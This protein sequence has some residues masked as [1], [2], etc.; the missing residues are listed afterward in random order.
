MARYLIFYKEPVMVVVDEFFTELLSGNCSMGRLWVR[1][2][3]AFVRV[4]SASY[5]KP[6]TMAVYLANAPFRLTITL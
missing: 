3:D 6:V 2:T 4:V 1:R 5:L